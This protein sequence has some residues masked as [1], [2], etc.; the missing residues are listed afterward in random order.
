MTAQLLQSRP[1]ALDVVLRNDDATRLYPPR[2]GLSADEVRCQLKRP[3]A[4]AWVEVPLD[5]A[6]LREVGSGAYLLSLDPNHLDV[7]GPLFVLLTGRPGLGSPILPAFLE[8]E[9]VVPRDFHA[10]RPHLE[11]TLV[12]GQLVGLHSRPLAGAT[13]AATLLQAPLLLGG[14]AVAGDA[15]LAATD[16]DGCFELP[17]LTGAT[18]DVQIAAARY[19]RTLVVPPPP[20]PGA[21][22]RL[23]SIP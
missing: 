19:R 9:V 3:G 6:I 13:I 20:A 5:P 17:L 1:G 4:T 16:E 11:R 7:A 2:P 23:F 22:V 21:P 8:A 18:V 12:V 14:V 10:P 15:V